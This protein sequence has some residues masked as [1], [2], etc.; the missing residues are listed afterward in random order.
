MGRGIQEGVVQL[1]PWTRIETVPILPSF[2]TSMHSLEQYRRYRD[3]IMHTRPIVEH[4]KVCEMVVESARTMANEKSLDMAYVQQL[5]EL[6]L[7][8]QV[9]FWGIRIESTSG[10]IRVGCEGSLQNEYEVVEATD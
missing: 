7:K 5:V 1:I 8:P 3:N 9:G 4:K 10:E 2:L 6:I